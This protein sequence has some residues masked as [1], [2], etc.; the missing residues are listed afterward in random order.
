MLVNSKLMSIDEVARRCGF[1]NGNYFAKVFRRVVHV[2][3]QQFRQDE[4]LQRSTI[5]FI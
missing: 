4:V 3:P 1:A 5:Q 2:S